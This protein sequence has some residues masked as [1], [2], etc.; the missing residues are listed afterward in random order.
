MIVEI[1]KYY[2][3]PGKLE[4]VKNWFGRVGITFFREYKVE[5]LGFLTDMDESQ[6][7]LICMLRWSSLAEREAKWTRLE[8]DRLWQSEQAA[9]AHLIRQVETTLLSTELS[10]Y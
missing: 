10:R 8:S 7:V 6:N 5:Q 3:I 4:D 9:S 2:A 1:R